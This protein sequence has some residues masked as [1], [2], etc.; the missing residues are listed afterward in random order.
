MAGST[1]AEWCIMAGSTIAEWCLMAGNTIAWP[2]GLRAFGNQLQRRAL[3][4]PIFLMKLNG[5]LLAH[6]S[7]IAIL[8]DTGT[9][10]SAGARRLL[11]TTECMA[12]KQVLLAMTQ[13]AADKAIKTSGF[14][15]EMLSSVMTIFLG[16]R[17]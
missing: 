1:I 15:C 7:S 14:I 8:V 16:F 6:G 5:R 10:N 4:I 9:E 12:Q 2:V 11:D 3:Y 13:I 17:V